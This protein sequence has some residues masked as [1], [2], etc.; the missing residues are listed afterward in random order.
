M[1]D[2]G[3]DLAQLAVKDEADPSSWWTIL[4][5]GVGCGILV[6]S[7]YFVSAFYYWAASGYEGEVVV[8]AQNQALADLRTRQE[9]QLQQRG[10]RATGDD[11]RVRTIPIAEAM[12]EVAREN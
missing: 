9:D 3:H 7:V 5:A 1:T 4:V 11:R 10:E 12:A 2:P 6:V 8:D